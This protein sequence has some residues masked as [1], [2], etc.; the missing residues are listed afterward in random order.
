MRRIGSAAWRKSA[1]SAPA[2]KNRLLLG[3]SV[4]D[5]AYFFE[6]DE[7][8]FHHLVEARK[9]LLD[10]L[11]GF[12]DFD[13]HGKILRQSEDFVGV[14][15]AGGTKAADSAQNGGAREPLLSKEFDDCLLQRL[16]PPLVGLADMDAHQSA[17]ARKFFVGHERLLRSDSQ[18]GYRLTRAGGRR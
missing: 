7:P 13:D 6:R 2:R 8:A 10:T 5:D 14:I 16:A 9:D 18:D 15:D 4:Q 11:G 1:S 12:D 3:G 17:F